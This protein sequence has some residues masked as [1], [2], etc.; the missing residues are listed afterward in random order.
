MPIKGRKPSR[1]M[2][3]KK[4]V[5]ISTAPV[6]SGVPRAVKVFVNKALRQTTEL[7]Y[8]SAV[9]LANNVSVYGSGLLHVAGAV[10]PGIGQGPGWCSGPVTP[11]GL[12]PLVAQGTTESTR[13]GNR[14]EPK[15]LKLRFS[16]AARY[17]TDAST[18][19]ASGG[20]INPYRGVPFNVRVIVFRHKYA[21]DDFAQNNI[22]Q[23]GATN[24]NLD[25]TVDDLFKPYNRDEYTIYY[26]KNFI[27]ETPQ[28]INVNGQTTN[29]ISP[30][31]NSFV[32]KSLSLPLPRHLLYND[33][34]STCTNAGMFMAVSVCNTDNTPV[35]IEHTRVYINAE[36]N[37]SFTDA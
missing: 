35:P 31:S 13:I 36:S 32:M 25:N 14:I 21:N 28:H 33:G 30:R 5:K 29:F 34:A 17:T 23:N 8:A 26:S 9:S 24:E 19:A 7:K 37:M 18:P 10:Y 27:M 11:S 20:N 16:L 22:L 4:S 2:S 1:K 15:S 6:K 3:K 12:I